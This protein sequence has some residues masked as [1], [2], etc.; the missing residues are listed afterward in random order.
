MPVSDTDGVAIVVL[1]NPTQPSEVQ[2]FDETP[3]DIGDVTNEPGSFDFSTVVGVEYS[4]ST[5]QV[6]YIVADAEI[7]STQIL[8]LTNPIPGTNPA[9]LVVT[10]NGLRLTP[11]AGIEYI[12]DDQTVTF[13][14]PQRLGASFSQGDIDAATDVQVYVDNVLLTYQLDYKIGRA[15]V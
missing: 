2:G 14:L 7:V 11:A 12:G 1:G 9:N 6:Q 8:T 4:W 10:R 3:F 13:G 15:H 5:P